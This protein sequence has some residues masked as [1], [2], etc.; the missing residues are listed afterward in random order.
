[1]SRPLGYGEGM[2]TPLNDYQRG[3]C[4]EFQKE[5]PSIVAIING[6]HPK[7]YAVCYYL[8]ISNDD[9]EQMGRCGVIR[10]AQKYRPEKGAR[11]AT[12]AFPNIRAAVQDGVVKITRKQSRPQGAKV[13]HG[14]RKLPGC[15]FTYFDMTPCK[16]ADSANEL[17]DYADEQ[18][19]IDKQINNYL[20]MVD[21]KSARMI[22]D[23]FG[24]NGNAMMTFN[25]IAKRYN[26]SKSWA[27]VHIR[28]MLS[29]IREKVAYQQSLAGNA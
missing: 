20:S 14:D 5:Y 8:R 11:F 27:A 28:N 4:E 10:A 18:K 25:Q 12:I 7:L 17:V 15:R 26:T 22:R 9:L 3:L 29:V 13:H 23:R 6:M 1:M 21:E 2:D 24:L 16:R 19:A